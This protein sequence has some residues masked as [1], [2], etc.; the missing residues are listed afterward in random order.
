MSKFK[1]VLFDLGGT[2]IKTVD[3]PEVFKRILEV[4]GVDVSV[5]DIAK[6][7]AEN[8]K[9]FDVEEMVKLGQDFWI[10]WNLRIL[11]RIG[12]QGDRCFLA[13]KI[14][15]LWWEYAELEIYSDALEALAQLK[16]KG[17]RIGIVTNGFE[18]DYKQI[19]RKLALTD[20]FDVAVGADACRKAKPAREIFFYAVNKLH[21]HPDE[22]IFIGDSIKY[23]YEG[24]KQAGLKP[25]LINREKK[26]LTNVEAITSLIEVLSYF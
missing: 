16:R 18:N 17:I 19:L 2:L 21:V 22:T 8:V 13:R 26:A 15:R 12:I 9:E 24:A 25:L 6:A 4:Y 3:V 7:H 23:D 1:A 5:A 11:E 10:K 20:Y 14:D